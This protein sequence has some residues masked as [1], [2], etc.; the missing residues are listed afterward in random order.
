MIK[1]SIEFPGNLES[2]QAISQF[3]VQSAKSSGL[4]DADIYALELAVDE[5][6]TNIIEHAYG[7][8]G[9]NKINCT[10]ESVL[11]GIKVIIKDSGCAFDPKDAQKPQIGVCLEELKSRGVGIYLMDRLMDEVNHA[12]IPGGGNVL[13]L[14]KR[15][16]V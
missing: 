11:D 5:A 15:H 6:C 1:K 9:D 13:T 14:V 8:Q 3:V 4:N 12:F 7:C 16:S 2:L 10:C